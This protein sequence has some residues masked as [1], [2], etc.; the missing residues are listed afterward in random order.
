MIDR[1]CLNCEI[2]V[3]QKRNSSRPRAYPTTRAVDP[4]AFKTLRT[5][6]LKWNQ[7]ILAEKAGVSVAT[8]GRAENDAEIRISSARLIETAIRNKLGW[9]I[10]PLFIGIDSATLPESG[11]RNS[12][13]NSQSSLRSIQDASLRAEP[14][15]DG[16][17]PAEQNNRLWFDQQSRTLWRRKGSILLPI[18]T[19]DVQRHI[20]RLRRL[21]VPTA[22]LDEARSAGNWQELLVNHPE[23][24]MSSEVYERLRDVWSHRKKYRSI[25]SGCPALKQWIKSIWSPVPASARDLEREQLKKFYRAMQS[26]EPDEMLLPGFTYDE[27][28]CWRVFVQA[29]PDAIRLLEKVAEITSMSN[30]RRM[31]ISL[32][33]SAL[34]K[35]DAPEISSRAAAVN[36]HLAREVVAS[37]VVDYRGYKKVRQFLYTAVEA[38]EFPVE[39]MLDFLH[40]YADRKWEFR[41][42]SEYYLDPTHQTFAR[43]IVKKLDRPLLRDQATRRISEYLLELLPKSL[44][45]NAQR[46][47]RT[48]GPA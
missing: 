13:Q 21:E 45:D 35:T 2:S 41:L 4:L 16:A 7:V 18:D 15:G 47:V 34:A 42:N 33:S 48:S 22:V 8:V 12:P 19:N 30:T 11:S 28:S 39:R 9:Q 31:A 43:S 44:L 32:L 24:L 26:Q 3:D 14:S 20:G 6:K 23:S 46:I 36:A 1:L 29:F 40:R 17:A 10:D 27:I 37:A 25:V 38:G 5:K